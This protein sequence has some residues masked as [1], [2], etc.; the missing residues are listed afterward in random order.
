MNFENVDHFDMNVD[1]F[2]ETSDSNGLTRYHTNSKVNSLTNSIT[3]HKQVIF[4][5]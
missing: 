5:Y 2:I 1:G 4:K 3:Q